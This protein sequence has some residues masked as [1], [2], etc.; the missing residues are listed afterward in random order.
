VCVHA[1][2]HP[3]RSILILILILILVFVDPYHHN[4]I[5]VSVSHT[6]F[7]PAPVVVPGRNFVGLHLNK[8]NG[9]VGQK[10]K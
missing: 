9:L 5:I 1:R 4:I 6:P 10:E 2:T 7:P 8:N 3:F